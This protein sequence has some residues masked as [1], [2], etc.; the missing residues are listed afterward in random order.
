MAAEG[1]AEQGSGWYGGE[2]V[3]YGARYGS[4]IMDIENRKIATKECSEW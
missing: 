1:L 4:V 3:I 2:F